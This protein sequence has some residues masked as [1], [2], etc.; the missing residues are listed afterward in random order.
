M[1]GAVPRKWLERYNPIPKLVYEGLTN[2]EIGKKLGMSFGQVQR[3]TQMEQYQTRYNKLIELSG[4]KLS[5]EAVKSLD[6]K[7]F[8]AGKKPVLMDNMIKLALTARSETVRQSATA[9]CLEKFPEFITKNIQ[10]VIQNVNYVPNPQD[11]KRAEAVTK[12]LKALAKKSGRLPDVDSD[13]PK[14]G[15][16]TNPEPA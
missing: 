10:S 5:R 3:V 9:W 14:G 6:A 8:L 16:G 15:K 4:I 7:K 13:G 12:D 2:L 1:G 11:L